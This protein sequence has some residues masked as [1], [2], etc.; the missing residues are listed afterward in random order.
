MISLLKSS[1]QK[2]L[3]EQLIEQFGCD[4]IS[5][6]KF[7][8]DFVFVE[9]SDKIC[10]CRSETVKKIA[11]STKPNFVGLYFCKIEQGGIRLSLDGAWLV[12]PFAKKNLLELDSEMVEDWMKGNDIR[13]NFLNLGNYVILCYNSLVLGCGKVTKSKT[14]IK[15]FVPKERRVYSDLPI[16]SS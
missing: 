1:R 12:K 2:K 9:I 7:F 13:G 8:S 5:F 14:V 10:L 4:R 16:P 6:I 3:L 11:S 15:N